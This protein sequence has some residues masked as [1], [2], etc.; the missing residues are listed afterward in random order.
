MG[1]RDLNASRRQVYR[2]TGH[3]RI[4]AMTHP[5]ERAN[6]RR[7]R[8]P[9]GQNSRTN[10]SRQD[11]SHLQKKPVKNDTF[12]TSPGWQLRYFAET[13]SPNTQ[14]LHFRNIAQS[15]Q[16][17]RSFRASFSIDIA[18]EHRNSSKKA[19]RSVRVPFADRIAAP[20]ASA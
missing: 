14:V 16:A 5:K 4:V 11:L 9:W 1:H 19:S 6:H 12:A 13:V 3:S 18:S 10:K 17:S 2:P 7:G 20:V 8:H 15:T